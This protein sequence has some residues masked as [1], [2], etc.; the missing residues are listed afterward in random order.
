MVS[1]SSK[2]TVRRAVVTGALALG[3]V[4]VTAGPA[5]AEPIEIPGV[6]T[7]ELPAGV[8]L[9]PEVT[10][11]IPQGPEAAPSQFVAPFTSVGQRAADVAQS[12][13]GSPYVYG[14][15]GPN[16]FDCSGLVQWAYEQVGVSVPRTSYQQAA[17][18][19][20]VSLDLLQPG[21][22]VSFYGGSHTGIYI[23]NG[24]IVHASTSS[25]PVKVAPLY[26]MPVDGAR[27]FA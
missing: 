13:I 17:A 10:N 23:G 12:K 5:M 20:A 11:L 15:T 9:P 14:A 24:N 2:N 22:V 8:S 25:Q 18:G 7:F 26:S 3:A 19:S 21:D 16:A 6:G 1:Q 4:T 27:R